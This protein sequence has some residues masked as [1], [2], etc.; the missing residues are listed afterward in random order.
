MSCFV[1][2]IRES[3]KRGRLPAGRRPS[4]LP[5]SADRSAAFLRELAAESTA[6]PGVGDASSASTPRGQRQAGGG[7]GGGALREHIDQLTREA[8]E[9][10]RGLTQ[11]V[12]PPSAGAGAPTRNAAHCASLRIVQA[13]GILVL[14]TAGGCAPSV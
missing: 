1:Q 7:A 5:P 4:P 2:E 11:Q 6:E 14:V 12:L 3:G 8:F 9:L 10:R 13:V